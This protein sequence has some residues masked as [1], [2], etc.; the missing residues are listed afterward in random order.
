MLCAWQR[1]QTRTRVFGMTDFIRSANPSAE[2]QAPPLSSPE[3]LTSIFKPGTRYNENV[4][5]THKAKFP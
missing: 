1:I 5:A 4:S 3:D 2:P